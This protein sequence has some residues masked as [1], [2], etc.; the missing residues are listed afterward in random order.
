MDDARLKALRLRARLYALIRAFFAERAV[1]ELDTPVLGQGATT[2]ANIDSFDTGFGG[3]SGAG[4]RRRFLRTS[5]EFWH[6]R[7]LVEGVGD[8]YELGKVFRDGEFGRRHNPEFTLLEWYRTGWDLPRLMSEVEALVRTAFAFAGRSAGNVERIS[9][10]EL[11]RRHLATDPLTASEDELRRLAA[12]V[13]VDA[14]RLDRDG[15]LD[16]LV[17]HRIEPALPPHGLTFVHDYPA[18]QAALAKVRKDR[19][20]ERVAERFELY[21]GQLELANGFNEL[22]DP[23]EQLGRFEADNRR[24]A[25]RGGEPLP[26]DGRF[27]AALEQGLPP[28]A[29]VALGVD[30][31]LMAMLEVDDIREVLAFAFPDA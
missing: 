30:R 4:A 27:L 10:R 1:L 12:G 21:V 19:D 22:S 11:F 6:K 14:S 9:Y 24:R 18:S 29:G 13:W 31:L 15:L 16:V 28:C 2:D 7:L 25:G 23:Q 17:S 20:G 8:C 26:I 5:P 3:P